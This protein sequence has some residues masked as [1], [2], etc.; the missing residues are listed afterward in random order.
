MSARPKASI[1]AEIERVYQEI[2]AGPASAH[3]VWIETRIPRSSVNRHIR[4]LLE[5][6]RIV[7]WGE[8]K[9]EDHSAYRIFSSPEMAQHKLAA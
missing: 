4:H 1:E 2:C 6:E 8:V 5:Q 3:D 7:V 9:P